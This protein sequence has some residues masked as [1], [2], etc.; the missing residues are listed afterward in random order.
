MYLGDYDTLT[1]YVVE[2][3]TGQIKREHYCGSFDTAINHPEQGQIVNNVP[4][5]YALFFVTI[6][7]GSDRLSW[8]LDV[9]S[10]DLIK[11]LS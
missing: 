6:Y 1:C 5:G 3:A 2:L 10:P 7:G 9:V 11:Q 8:C 4:A